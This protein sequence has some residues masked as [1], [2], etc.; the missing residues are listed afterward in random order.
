MGCNVSVV[1]SRLVR[2]RV[3]DVVRSSEPV[4][5]DEMVRRRDGSAI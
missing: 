4:T 1:I 3:V 2:L 5:E